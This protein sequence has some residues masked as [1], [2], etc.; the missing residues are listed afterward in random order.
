[1][2]ERCIL[3]PSARSRDNPDLMWMWLFTAAWHDCQCQPTAICCAV[4]LQ[5]FLVRKSVGGVWSPPVKHQLGCGRDTWG[6]VWPKH[7]SD[8]P[9]TL[10]K[11]REAFCSQP[12]SAAENSLCLYKLESLKHHILLFFFFFSP[13]SYK[14]I[15]VENVTAFCKLYLTQGSRRHRPIAVYP[16]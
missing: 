6:R 12:C 1:M 9:S 7:R 5:L 11:S 15:R 13:L 10:L 2:P 14:V 4:L 16:L 8:A 3:R